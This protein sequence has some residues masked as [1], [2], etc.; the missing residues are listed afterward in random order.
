MQQQ[1]NGIIFGFGL[2]VVGG[3][4]LYLGR[5]QGWAADERKCPSCAETIKADAKLCRYCKTDLTVGPPA[6]SS[7][8]R[9]SLVAA[10]VLL[11]GVP[12]LAWFAA[13]IAAT[14]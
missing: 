13:W 14:F 3:V 9:F 5:E 2:A 8:S 10:G 4:L 6:R 12:G 7:R 11:I 1:Q